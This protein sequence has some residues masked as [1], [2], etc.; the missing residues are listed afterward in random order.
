MR[1]S[2]SPAS[3]ASSRAPSS[4]SARRSSPSIGASGA[5][6]SV[7]TRGAADD[8]PRP[9]DE[10]VDEERLVRGDRA[11]VRVADDPRAVGVRQDRVVALGQEARRRRREG[12]GSGPPGTSKQLATVLVAEA[13]QLRAQA[14]DRA[15]EAAHPR[16]RAHVVDAR[17]AERGEVAQQQLVGRAGGVERAPE[18]ALGGRLDGAAV[19]SPQAARRQLHE[20]RE[21]G[22]RVAER[23]RLIAGPLVGQQAP[24]V[25]ERARLRLDERRGP[26]ATSR[27][28]STPSSWLPNSARRRR[29]MTGCTCG[30]SRTQ[31]R[32]VT[33]CSVQ[34][35]SAIR[36]TSRRSMR[37]ASSS[38]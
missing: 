20:R 11:P 19:A 37:P 17:G 3:K 26:I 12:S 15:A 31:S 25:A 38:G 23:A 13:A 14:I 35:M 1:R 32:A 7:A 5:I 33:T 4:A 8:L 30:R 21:R 2:S 9:A 10:A 29:S 34:R 22:Q 18:P 6:T 16:P 28:R 27:S 36:T 24:D